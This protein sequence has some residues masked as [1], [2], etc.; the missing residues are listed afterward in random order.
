MNGSEIDTD[1]DRSDTQREPKPKSPGASRRS[2]LKAG[3]L[4]GTVGI[5]GGSSLFEGVASAQT[6]PSITAQ[7]SP[8]L[9]P[10]LQELPR[11]NVLEPVEE[12]DC[13]ACYE[14]SIREADR[15][16][17]PEL[18]NPTHL[19]T[20]QGQFPGPTIEAEWGKNVRVKWK[21]E[22]D[23]T[24][25]FL[26]YDDTLHGTDDGQPQVRTVTHLHGGN[27]PAES[28]GYPEAWFTKGFQQTGDFFERTVYEYPNEQPGATLWYHDHVLGE[29]RLNVYAGLAGFYLLRERDEKRYDLPR[30]KYEIPIAIQDRSFNEDGSLYYPDGSEFYSNPHPSV[31][32]EFFGDT[33]VVNGAV[34][35]TLTVEPRK[36]RLRLLNG[37]NSRFYALRLFGYDTQNDTRHENAPVPKIVQIGTDGGFLN[38]PVAVDGRLVM[39][40][41]ERADTVLDFSNFQGQ[42]F[43]VYNDASTP[44][45]GTFVDDPD[46][47]NVMLIE[48]EDA[49]GEVH[50]RS[51]V[52]DRFRLK[53]CGKKI[54]AVPEIP[55]SSAD[56]TRRSFLDETTDDYGRLLLQLNGSSFS[57]PITQKPKLGQTE[58]W[59]VANQTPD[60]HPIHLHLV[61]FQVIDRRPFDTDTFDGRQFDQHGTIDYTGPAVGPD[62]NE[63]GWK[64]TVRMDPGEVTRFVVHFGEYDHLFEDRSGRYLW[65]C[66]IL[67]HEDHDMMRPY[68]VVDD[69]A[70]CPDGHSDDC[71]CEQDECDCDRCEKCG[72][73]HGRHKHHG[74]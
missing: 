66:H 59:E 41:G 47:P 13:T 48:V 15:Q 38:E 25:Q 28:D 22:I 16:L 40:P 43:L 18:P 36:Y 31:V 2:V 51:R 42:S 32:P 52:P 1:R 58:I 65:H 72:G 55:V 6:G 64:D 3:G 11:P 24:S 56:R 33:A 34:W 74:H 14:V 54:P 46:L 68:E 9:T 12:N 39:G 21:N 20:Y 67:E 35:P 8:S 17:H 29:T 5:L 57:D 10:F 44:F 62:P 53:R 60:T 26:P 69:A 63:S 37:S 73:T 49:C 30:G 45:D 19:W 4:A 7:T 50:D 61:Q 70:L 27:T 71:G 23:E